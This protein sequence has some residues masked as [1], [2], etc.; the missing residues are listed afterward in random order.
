MLLVCCLVGLL[1][2]SLCLL[3]VC[4]CA[5]VVLL[6]FCYCDGGIFVDACVVRARVCFC[7]WRCCPLFLFCCRVCLCYAWWFLVFLLLSSDVLLC[8]F[9]VLNACLLFQ[10]CL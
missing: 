1:S 3:S 10:L 7:D 4:Y 8:L 2:V 9:F 5:V 6:C